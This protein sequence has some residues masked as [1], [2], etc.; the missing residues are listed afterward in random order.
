MHGRAPDAVAQDALRWAG[1][2][3]VTVDWEHGPASGGAASMTDSFA[4]QATTARP[5]FYAS[6]LKVAPKF[7]NHGLVNRDSMVNFFRILYGVLST[8]GTLEEDVQKPQLEL[9][10]TLLHELSSGLLLMISQ[11]D[12]SPS[13]IRL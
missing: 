9:G 11:D 1:N 13:S 8:G 5:A 6:L 10:A 12:S 7:K 3:L 2:F 4:V